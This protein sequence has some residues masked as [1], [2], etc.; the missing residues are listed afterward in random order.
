MST[1]AQARRWR[2]WLERF[3]GMW[4]FVLANKPVDMRALERA[5]VGFKL[6]FMLKAFDYSPDKI[7]LNDVSWRQLVKDMYAIVTQQERLEREQKEA[8]YNASK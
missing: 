5:Q 8:Q 4:Q 3:N 1:K 2:E 6:G 7:P